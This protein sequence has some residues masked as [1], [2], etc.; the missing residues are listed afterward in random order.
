M[1]GAT[2]SARRQENPDMQLGNSGKARRGS[3]T[4][5][6]GSWPS[7]AGSIPAALSTATKGA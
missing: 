7:G 5:R 1:C 2:V 3:G 4:V 6:A